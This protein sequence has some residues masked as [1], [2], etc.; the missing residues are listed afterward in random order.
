MPNS[1]W[2]YTCDYPVIGIRD[3]SDLDDKQFV[4]QRRKRNTIVT[5]MYFIVI[6][7]FVFVNHILANILI[8]IFK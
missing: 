7:A 6:F 5:I 3:I 8:F 4:R 1:I 2:R